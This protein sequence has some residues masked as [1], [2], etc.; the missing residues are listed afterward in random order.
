[1]NRLMPHTGSK[2][3]RKHIIDVIF[4][5][6]VFFVFAASSLAVLMLASKIY[7]DTSTS[8]SD[9]Y[10]SRTAFAYVSEKLRQHDSR[11]G[12]GVSC[13]DME[14][15]DCLILEENES[16]TVTYIYMYDGSLKE[17]RVRSDVRVSPES[18]LDITPVK[19]FSVSSEGALLFI[20]ITADDGTEYSMVSSERSAQ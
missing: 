11:S 2:S 14:G 7:D 16:G 3:S 13:G 19:D 17:L 9:N 4:P 6:A 20:N 12:G 1:M 10:S 18:G 8:A 15:S 5:I